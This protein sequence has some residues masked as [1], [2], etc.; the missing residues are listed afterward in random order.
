MKFPVAVRANRIQ[1]G[2]STANFEAWL[3][4]SVKMTVKLAEQLIQA[5]KMTAKFGV[6]RNRLE[7]RARVA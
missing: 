1:G 2:N 5:V 3:V 6:K 7:V 4:H